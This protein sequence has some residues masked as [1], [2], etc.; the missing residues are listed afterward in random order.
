MHYTNLEPKQHSRDFLHMKQGD[1]FPH[2]HLGLYVTV[3]FLRDFSSCRFSNSWSASGLS[4]QRV[5]SPL[6]FSDS[7]SLE[8]P[9][10]YTD[11]ACEGC[12]RRRD[13]FVFGFL[14]EL[15]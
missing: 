13:R 11:W 8:N 6:A 5:D 12:H 7:R 15:V 1:S 14:E 10:H 3:V 2:V 9:G 4:T